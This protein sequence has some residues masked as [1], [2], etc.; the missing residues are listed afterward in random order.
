MS[1]ITRNGITSTDSNTDLAVTGLGTGVPDIEAGYKVGG[2]V[3]KLTGIAPST[4]G[5]VLTSDGTN[6]TSA[7]AAGGADYFSAKMSQNQVFSTGTHTKVLYATELADSANK[8]NPSTSKWTPAAGSVFVNAAVHLGLSANAYLIIQI[9]KNG[10]AI[11]RSILINASTP[12]MSHMISF[13]DV[14]DGDDYYE[15]YVYIDDAQRTLDAG[16]PP[17]AF[18]Q[19]FMV[20]PA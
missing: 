2:T 5:N 14:A 1:T 7:A 12:P 8:Y 16:N 13:I 9:Y 15:I 10:S 4:S 19:G 18:F 20:L 3:E 11:A 6:W 17:A